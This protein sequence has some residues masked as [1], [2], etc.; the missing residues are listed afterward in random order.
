L[1]SHTWLKCSLPLVSKDESSRQ[2]GVVAVATTTA[3][4]GA[5]DGAPIGDVLVT[6]VG[7]GSAWGR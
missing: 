6:A 7:P 2:F 5:E 4:G 3:F 1:P